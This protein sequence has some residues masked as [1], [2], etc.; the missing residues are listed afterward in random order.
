MGDF[1]MAK[2][3]GVSCTFQEFSESVEALAIA[4]DTA[5]LFVKAKGATPKLLQ[6]LL[7]QVTAELGNANARISEFEP[8]LNKLRPLGEF[9]E[10]GS[11]RALNVHR[12]VVDA[13]RRW[14]YD[15]A[16]AVTLAAKSDL[17]GVVLGSPAKF[18]TSLVL[19]HGDHAISAIEVFDRLDGAH[20]QLWIQSERSAL[21]GA[22]ASR[23][24]AA[25][26]GRYSIA[27]I[28][29]KYGVPAHRSGAFKKAVQRWK[30]SNPDQVGSG[31][32]ETKDRL[33]DGTVLLFQP[34]AVAVLIREYLI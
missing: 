13:A 31:W 12:L 6:T 18:D 2:D 5:M 8:A 24:P 4:P 27:D 22:Q 16:F 30:T 10:I 26:F 9:A 20:A 21:L 32:A 25:D 33:S 19:E 14:H 11:R 7:D 17:S 15:I 23:D 29:T 28:A 34:A 3:N 1:F